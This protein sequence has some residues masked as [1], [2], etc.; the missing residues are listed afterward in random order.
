[1]VFEDKNSDLCLL[2]KTKSFWFEKVTHLL[3]RTKKNVFLVCKRSDLLYDNNK[4]GFLTI[5]K[6]YMFFICFKRMK[7]IFLKREFHL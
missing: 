1:M 4:K 6:S 5:E 7:K 3:L 2:H